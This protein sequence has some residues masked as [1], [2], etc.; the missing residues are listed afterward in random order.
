MRV[1][2][3]DANLDLSALKTLV[4]INKVGGELPA[5]VIDG[6]THTGF[7]SLVEMRELLPELA[8]NDESVKVMD[9]QMTE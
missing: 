5:L 1:Y 4:N 3:F 8:E 2:A 9:T 6:D 7:K